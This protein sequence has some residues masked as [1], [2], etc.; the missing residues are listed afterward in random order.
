MAEDQRLTEFVKAIRK[1][2]PRDDSVF[3]SLLVQGMGLLRFDDLRLAAELGVSRPSVTRWR[4]GANA[5]HPA[6]RGPIYAFLARRARLALRQAAE[7]IRILSR[8]GRRP[9]SR[10]RVQA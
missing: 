2:D 8:M 10:H 7:S 4:N 9:R 1:A 3:Q 6:M 5:P